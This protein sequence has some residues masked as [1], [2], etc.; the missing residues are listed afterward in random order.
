MDSYLSKA[1]AYIEENGD[2]VERARLAGL[3]GRVRPEPKIVR[4]LSIRQNEDGGYPYGMI[5]GRPSAIISTATGLQWMSELRL[6]SAGFVDR[7][8]AYLLSVQ[9]PEGAWEETPAVIK[10]DP[11]AHVRPGQSGA[12]TYCTALVTYWLARLAGPGHDAVVRGA[13]HLRAQ[14]FTAAPASEPVA[15]AVLVTAALA[16]VDGVSAP[17]VSAGANALSL[18]PADTWTADELVDLLGAFYGAQFAADHP[19]VAGGVHRLRAKQRVDGGWASGQSV[20]R[21]VD[22]SL[23][24]LGA[25]LAFGVAAS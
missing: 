21:D 18:I 11:P 1:I 13:A 23:R 3:L 20:D 19:L 24:A 4:T 15:T 6:T 22:L 10:Y 9:R 14:R 8:V 12:R 7:A 25:M 16:L 2:E 17:I 5:P